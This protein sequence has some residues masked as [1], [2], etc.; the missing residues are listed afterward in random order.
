[1]GRKKQVDEVSQYPR[2]TK[3]EPGPKH[4]LAQAV[5]DSWALLH[6]ICIFS[7]LPPTLV[8]PVTS[9]PLGPSLFLSLP[10]G[11]S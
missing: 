3:E 6:G 9:E 11:P 4:P 10:C 2:A 5:W 1:M 8:T 7:V